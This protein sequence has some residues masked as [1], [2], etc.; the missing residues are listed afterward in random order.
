MCAD[1]AHDPGFSSL[2]AHY[3][4]DPPRC[5]GAEWIPGFSGMELLTCYCGGSFAFGISLQSR[6]VVVFRSRV[7]LL[8]RHTAWAKELFFGPRASKAR[9]A[10]DHPLVFDASGASPLR[11]AGR[12]SRFRTSGGLPAPPATRAEPQDH[13]RAIKFRRRRS[14]LGLQDSG[15]DLE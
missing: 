8:Q 4:P 10:S 15:L 14:C 11:I 9:V 2:S 1:F 3:P 12:S 5:G 13:G 7:V 6:R